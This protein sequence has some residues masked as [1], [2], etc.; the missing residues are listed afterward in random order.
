MIELFKVGGCVR[1]EIMGITPHDIDYAVVGADHF[2]DMEHWLQD[3]GATIW[4]SKPEF[5]TIRAN[6]KGVNA[7]FVLT[8]RDGHY[9]DGRHPDDVQI[10][11]LY[12]DLSRRDLTVNA[13]AQRVKDGVIIDPFKG[14]EDIDAKILRAVGDP[15]DRINEDALRAL[16]AIRFSITKGFRIEPD[17]DWAIRTQRT[18]HAIATTVS[19]DRVREELDKM[20]RFDQRKSFDAMFKYASIFNTVLDLG[21]WFKPTTGGR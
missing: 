20:F 5:G 19:A 10:G 18:A 6:L 14:R 4:L 12:D 8:R 21:I 2:E 7:D 11:S 3:K 17:L 13:I 16:R 9:S 15:V 1:D